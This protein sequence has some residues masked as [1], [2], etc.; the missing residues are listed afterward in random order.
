MTEN[1]HEANL[2]PLSKHA[3][4]EAILKEHRIIAREEDIPKLACALDAAY[5]HDRELLRLAAQTSYKFDHESGDP[6]DGELLFYLA[7]PE[8]RL[9]THNGKIKNRVRESPQASQI[10]VLPQA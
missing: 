2:E 7:D 8:M 4:I 10:I 3:W 1:R 6:T 9:L 5:W